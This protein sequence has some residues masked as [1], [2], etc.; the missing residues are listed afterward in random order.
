MTASF[1]VLGFDIGGTKIA[2]CLGCSDGKIIASGRVDNKERHPDDVLP[3][4]VALG[5]QLLA[6]AGMTSTDLTAVGI[7]APAP[8]DIPGG[9]ITQPTNM[10][11]WVDVPIRDY[12]RDAF[13]T[14]AYM[15]N[16]ANAGALAEWFFGTGKKCRNLLYLTMST[17]I[18]GGIITNG[19]LVHGHDYLAGE[20]G[21]FS[22]DPDGPQCNC[23][24]RGCYE[25]FCG[26]RAMAQR[27][28]R[29][30]AGQPDHPIV[31]YANGNYDAI[32]MICLEKAV[33]DGD[34]Y[35][36]ALW[37]EMCRRNAQGIGGLINIFNPE[38][39]VLG[40]IAW[41]AG[42]LFMTPLQQY[43][44]QFCWPVQLRGCRVIPSGLKRRIGDY[45]GISVALNYLYEQDRFQPWQEQ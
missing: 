1:P 28:Q 22:I 13:A 17:G 39:I 26:G 31:R 40:T 18:G 15:D 30:L 43:L 9:R 23:G 20:V 4:L 37:D 10:K 11:K 21:H 24:I 3:E 45:A 33:R 14:T 8:H 5:R 27:M 34:A 29:E 35:A 42:D 38:M 32:D 41:A 25:A 12:L 16:D 36:V 2:V 44:P 6:D 7:S 19:R